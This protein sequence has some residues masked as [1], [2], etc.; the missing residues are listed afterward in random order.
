MIVRFVYIVLCGCGLFILIVIVSHRVNILR[1]LLVV[2]TWVFQ[3]EAIMKRAALNILGC[4]LL[5]RC[6]CS[7][8]KFVCIHLSWV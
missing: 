3:F 5:N 8:G 7:M 4:H 2:D 1:I 6:A